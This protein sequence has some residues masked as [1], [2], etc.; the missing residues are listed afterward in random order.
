M[1]KSCAARSPLTYRHQGRTLE[2]EGSYIYP[3][4]ERLNIA[5]AASAALWP[6]HDNSAAPDLRLGLRLFSSF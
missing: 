5:I 4:A 1:A 2:F 3:L 6:G